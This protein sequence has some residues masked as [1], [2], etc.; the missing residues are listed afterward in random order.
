MQPNKI[1]TVL[2]VMLSLGSTNVSAAP[3]T[4]GYV[5]NIVGY[6][7]QP[8]NK[9]GN[10]QCSATAFLVPDTSGSPTLANLSAAVLANSALTSASIAATVSGQNISCQLIVP[11]SFNNVLAGQKVVVAYTVRVRDDIII[12][13][14]VIPPVPLPVSGNRTTRQT[15]PNLT[16]TSQ[17]LPTVNVYL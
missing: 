16:P 2:G 1:F 9:F 15:I 10:V 12:D 5:L 6:L 4:G 17:T 14:T 8:I 7:R 3:A 11:F 13:P